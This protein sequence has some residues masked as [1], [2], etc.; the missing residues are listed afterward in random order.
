MKKSNVRVVCRDA[1][2]MNPDV[3]TTCAVED[4]DLG[5]LASAVNLPPGSIKIRGA[6]LIDDPGA[7]TPRLL[8]N[9]GEITETLVQGVQSTVQPFFRP[10]VERPVRPRHPQR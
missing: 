9:L 10:R 6:A 5:H 8:Y 7:P 4:L 2:G 1:S 3:L